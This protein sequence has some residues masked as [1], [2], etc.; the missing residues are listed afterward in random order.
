MVVL[1]TSEYL[2]AKIQIKSTEDTTGTTFRIVGL[3]LDNEVLLKTITGSNGGIV[4]TN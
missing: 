4:T 3:G 1:S 2:G